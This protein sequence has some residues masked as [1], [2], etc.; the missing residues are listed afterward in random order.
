MK[1]SKPKICSEKKEYYKA[2]ID[3]ARESVRLG[4]VVPHERVRVWLKALAEGK[5]VPRPTP[6]S[7]STP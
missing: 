7:N 6:A 2:A 3:K 5:N 1:K 4:R